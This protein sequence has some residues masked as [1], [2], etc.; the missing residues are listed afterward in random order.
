MT[1]DVSNIVFVFRYTVTQTNHPLQSYAWICNHPHDIDDRDA[2][3]FLTLVLAQRF[4]STRT[5]KRRRGT[6]NNIEQR[7]PTNEGNK[8]KKHPL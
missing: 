3:Y 5:T 7:V 4:H 8:N 6:F 1:G 2:D